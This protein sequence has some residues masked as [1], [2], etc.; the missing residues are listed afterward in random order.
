MEREA[1]VVILGAGAAGLAAADRLSRRGLSVIV[2]EA[3]D[4]VGGR[5]A[6]VRDPVADIPLELGAEF[7]HGQPPLLLKRIRQA[8]LKVRPCNDRHRVL[9][10]GKLEDA[11]SSFA[12]QEALT[13]VT[14]PDRPMAAWVEEQARA[15]AWPPIVGAMAGSYVRGFYAADPRVAS[16]LAIARMERSARE[17]GGTTPSRVME[18]YD[19]VLHAM[20]ARLPPDALLLNAVAQEVR[21]KRGAVRVRARTQRGT[22][23][24]TFLARHA[25]VTLPV[26]VLRAKPPAAGAVRFLPRVREQERAWNQL[27]M[28]PLVKVLLRFRKAFWREREETAHVGMFHA[29]RSPFLTW[30]TLS[31]HRGTR[32]LVGWSGGPA[33]ASLSRLSEAEVMAR[34]LHGLSQ[35]FHRPVRELEA[36]LESWRVQDWQQEPFTRGGYA[37]IP[38]GA[39][40][41][42]EALAR[43]VDKTLFFAGEATHSGG[44]EGTVHG[45]LET[46]RRAADELLAGRSKA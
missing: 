43:P 11:D 24:G 32:H 41:A 15:N 38:S 18:G 4:R 7:V 39:M 37:V 29:P 33:A 27:T 25:V 12:F 40:D 22:P 14:G 20:A 3:R 6:T 2:L 5:V 34:A 31:P 45:A 8:G 23:L 35:L 16:T 13:E 28:G 42:V 9:W 1:D 46:G 26:G 19:R 30:W 36:L 10:R 21:W 17:A 44:E